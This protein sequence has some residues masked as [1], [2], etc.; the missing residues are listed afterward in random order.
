MSD[1]L[2]EEKIT[3]LENSGYSK[4]AIELYINKINVG[5]IEAADVVQSYTGP[6][7]DTCKIY[8]KI[9]IKNVIEDSKFQYLGCPASAACGSIVTD[10]VKGKTLR[11][12]EGMTAEDIIE[13]LGG[14]P[15]DECHCAT[16]VLTTLCK[17]IKKYEDT[18][19]PK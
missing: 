1:Q 6:C 13:K 15:G 14:L 9:N 18:K 7:G 17:A 16:L 2:T 11:E 10:M 12:A 8:L 19:N 5:A 4:K 3:L